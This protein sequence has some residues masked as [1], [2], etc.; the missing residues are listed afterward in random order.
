MRAV[1]QCSDKAERRGHEASRRTQVHGSFVHLDDG[2]VLQGFDRVAHPVWV[3]KRDVR[4]GLSDVLPVGEVAREVLHA[5]VEHVL[6]DP[7]DAARRDAHVPRVVVLDGVH[8]RARPER[9]L[10]E[11]GNSARLTLEAVKELARQRVAPSVRVR[12][13]VQDNDVQG[14][15]RVAHGVARRAPLHCACLVQLSCF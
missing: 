11:D 5:D 1:P 13:K 2:K 7:A 8:V 9:A 15:S 10:D 12:V 3:E 14:R 4:V 6:L